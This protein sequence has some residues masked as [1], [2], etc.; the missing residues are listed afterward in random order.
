MMMMA[1]KVIM[2]IQEQILEIISLSNNLIHDDYLN[3]QLSFD[4]GLLECKDL[5][6]TRSILNLTA[7]SSITR[8]HELQ[9]PISIHPR[10]F[11]LKICTS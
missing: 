5:E 3:Y 8:L 11:K 1:L 4:I 2:T 6:F 9:H 7:T 10:T